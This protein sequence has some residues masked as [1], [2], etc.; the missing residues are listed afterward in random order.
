MIYLNHIKRTTVFE[1]FISVRFILTYFITTLDT[2]EGVSIIGH[3]LGHG[4]VI[5]IE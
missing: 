5:P 2:V 1:Y 3:I 4:Q